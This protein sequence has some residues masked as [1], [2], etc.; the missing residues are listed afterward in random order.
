MM[1]G[2]APFSSLYCGSASGLDSRTRQSYSDVQQRVSSW[3]V[4]NGT[5]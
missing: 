5:P 1:S 4:D 3:I 2:S